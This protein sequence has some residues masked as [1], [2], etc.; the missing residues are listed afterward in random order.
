MKVVDFGLAAFVGVL[1]AGPA[2]VLL[3]TPEYMAP[4]Q[5][6]GEPVTAAADIYALGLVLLQM[7]TGSL[8]WTAA[9]RHGLLQ[10][11]RRSPQVRMPPVAGV[12]AAIVSLCEQ[13]LSNDP[14]QRPSSRHLARVMRET[15]TEHD[16]DPIRRP[17]TSACR[18]P[19]TGP[20]RR[21]HRQPCRGRCRPDNV[22]ADRTAGRSRRRS[23]SS[24][25]L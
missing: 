22:R 9:D 15:L 23:R 3:G 25:R 7:L 24:Q 10:E 12:P 21:W 19:S 4:E 14:Q 20:H 13:C 1:P 8:P 5:L 11:R 16:P 6:R 18:W 2:G 17:S